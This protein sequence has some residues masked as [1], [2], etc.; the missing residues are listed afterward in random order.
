M[1]VEGAIIDR[2]GARPG[3]VRFR[4]DRVVEVGKVGTDSTRG[5]VRRVRGIVVPRGVN[6]HTHMGDA[7]STR[8]PPHAPLAEVV[9]APDG[10]KFRLLARASAAAKREAM[11]RALRH[12]AAEGTGAILDFREEGREGVELLRAAACG[13]DLSVIAL[14]R[15]LRRPVD[16]G[17][18][19][20]LLAVAD[21][22]GL[23]SARE[24]PSATRQTIARAVRR[25]GGLYA[26]HASESVREPVDDYL[27]P[28]PDLLVHLTCATDDDL[29]AVVRE[30]VAVAVCPRSNALFGRRSALARLEAAGATALLGTDNAMF[31]SP[32]MFRELEFA[33]V[34]ARLARRPVSPE[35]L[36]RAVF[37]DPWTLL[38][39]EEMA[40]ISADGPCRPLA[41][42]LPPDDPWYQLVT[43]A[44]EQLIVQ[45]GRRGRGA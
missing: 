18:L 12:L 43:R 35:Y 28:R 15:P 29:A 45:P 8:E 21:G 4:G 2:D 40:R 17:E 6:G 16:R 5:R 3:Y 20:E 42:R 22:V 7:V 25:H 39:R 24:E 14:G 38:H 44:T 32:T 41:L 30:K 13:I 33:Y 37:I 10:Y 31:H 23:S 1:I 9:G 34:S 27:R 26:L 36:G 11:T 19:E